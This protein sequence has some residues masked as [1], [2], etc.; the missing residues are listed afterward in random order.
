M[1]LLLIAVL[2]SISQAPT[3][4]PRKAPNRPAR[5]SQ[6]VK[7]DAADNMKPT[8]TPTVQNPPASEKDQKTGSEPA[9][10]NT[11]ETVVIREP[12]TVSVG[13]WDRAYVIFTGLLV[14]IGSFGVLAALRTLKAVK[15]QA[16]IMGQQTA[17]TEKAAEAAKDQ[18]KIAMRDL[19]LLINRERPRITVTVDD[20]DFAKG[21]SAFKIVSYKINCRCPTDAF[22]MDTSAE[23]FIE[24][25]V[26]GRISDHI[27]I[28]NLETIHGFVKLERMA[29]ILTGL[30]DDDLMAKVQASLLHFRGV[31]KYRGVHLSDT[32]PPYS[33][34]FHHRWVCGPKNATF[35]GEMVDHW[36]PC[37]P[38]EDNQQT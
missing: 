38:P 18:A 33:T 9:K 37:G 23:A 30:T 11:Q 27:P 36:E 1:R 35:F 24:E 15:Q 19:E 34:T 10:T 4:I 26:L 6:G 21:Y 2:L 16:D 8:T 31:I 12:I 5:G 29:L 28:T 17:A 7:K 13:W 22:I 32:E 14:I 25:G 20:F 3:P